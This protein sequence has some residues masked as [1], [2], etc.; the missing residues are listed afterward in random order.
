MQGNGCT[1]GAVFGVK[2]PKIL[3]KDASKAPMASLPRD[4]KRRVLNWIAILLLPAAVIGVANVLWQGSR[5]QPLPPSS[6]IAMYILAVL[7]LAFLH[8]KVPFLNKMMKWFVTYVVSPF[9]ISP[10][11]LFVGNSTNRRLLKEI[12]KNA[13]ALQES[14]LFARLAELTNGGAVPYQIFH[15][16]KE[17]KGGVGNVE[18]YRIVGFPVDEAEIIMWLWYLVT[19]ALSLDLTGVK[20]YCSC[21]CSKGQKG[22]EIVLAAPCAIVGS[23]KGNQASEFVMNWLSHADDKQHNLIRNHHFIIKKQTINGTDQCYVEDGPNKY[24]PDYF[25]QDTPPSAERKLTDYALLMKLPLKLQNDGGG[26]Q[27]TERQTI[28]LLAGCKAGGQCG[29]TE[30]FITPENLSSLVNK[31]S[32]RY[33]QILLKVEYNYVN[34]GRPRVLSKEIIKEEEMLFKPHQEKGDNAKDSIS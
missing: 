8:D 30:W 21:I 4:W 5:H 10:I 31:Y 20:T 2:Q 17:H 29:L 32:S 34:E 25:T 27:N 33:F 6:A 9:V 3:N 14:A 7:F 19:S 15:S 13:L 16:H 24:E 23:Q 26:V 28:L 11:L 18:N 12:H 22:D 1:I